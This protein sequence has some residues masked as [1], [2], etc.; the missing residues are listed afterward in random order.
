MH[1]V[2]QKGQQNW[3]TEK[4]VI[5]FELLELNEVFSSGNLLC[6]LVL[7][8]A[9]LVTEQLFHHTFSAFLRYKIVSFFT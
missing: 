6:V 9:K 2:S 8:R 4:D 1:S 3:A 7:L 5:D